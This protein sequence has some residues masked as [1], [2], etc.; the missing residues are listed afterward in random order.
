MIMG[1]GILVVAILTA[2]IFSLVLVGLN[3]SAYAGVPDTTPPILIIPPDSTYEATALDTP[4]ADE[5][6]GRTAAAHVRSRPADRP[7][8]CVRGPRHVQGP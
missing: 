3:Q 5:S 2:C 7:Q 6:R 8:T 4:A 1:M